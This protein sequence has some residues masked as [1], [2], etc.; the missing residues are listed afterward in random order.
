MKNIVTIGGGTG[1]FAVLTALK[2]IPNFALSAIVT[3]SD[4]GGSTGKLRDAYG[5]LPMGDARQALVALSPAGE[6][7]RELFAYRFEK[8]DVTGH[9][10]GNLFLAAL[11]NILGSEAEAIKEAGRL[12]RVNGYVIPATDCPTV[13]S[14][15][16]SDGSVIEGE[17]AITERENDAHIASIRLA[18]PAPLSEAARRTLATADVIILGPGTLYASTIAPLLADGMQEAIAASKA[19]LVYIGNLFT[20]KGHSAGLPMSRH[21]QEVEAYA[22][23]P[24]DRILIHTGTFSDDV[25]GWYAKEDEYPVEDDLGEDPRVVR[26]GIA[27]V[28]VVPPVTGDPL[29]RSLMRHDPELLR[30]ALTPLL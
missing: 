3:T 10:L 23:R 16:L 9:N 29:R 13:L 18:E 2:R 12:L 26:A 19:T 22:G 20:K 27:S 7:L 8:G 25:L 11:S 6:R 17:N 14:A 1:T 15:T 4:D 5:F 28:N 30:I 24:F 21:I